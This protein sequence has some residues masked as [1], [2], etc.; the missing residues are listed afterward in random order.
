MRKAQVHDKVLALL[1]DTIANA[2][3]LEFLLE[4]L[5]AAGD[6]VGNKGPGQPVQAAVDRIV[7]RAG[8]DDFVF[9]DLD[10]DL[11]VEGVGQ[12]AL[13]SLDGDLMAVDLDLDARGDGDVLSSDS[14]HLSRPPY[15]TKAST[16]PPTFCFL[17]SLSVI[18]PFEVERMA[19]PSPF[20][21]RGASSQLV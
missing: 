8:D 2:V 12:S 7:A 16:S 21:T 15:Q 9:L 14:R 19:M 1:G 17:A 10:A 11:G 4:G 6:H 5:V 13:R 3:D 20:M 18:T